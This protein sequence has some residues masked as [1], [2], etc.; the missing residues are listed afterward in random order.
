V[1]EARPPDV[2]EAPAA[3]ALALPNLI[4]IGAQKCGTSSLHNYLAVHPQ[5]SMSRIKEINFFNDDAK[6]AYG[7]EWYARHFEPGE[8]RGESSPAYTFLPESMGTAERMHRLVPDARLIYLVRDPVERIRSNYIHMRALELESRPFGEA[9][10]DPDG[11]YVNHTRYAT[12]LQPFIELF[13]R[14]RLLIASQEKLFSE[15]A[16][17]MRRIFGFLGVDESF[18][19]PEFERIWGRSE[20]K[21]KV[22]SSLARAAAALQTRGLFPTLPRNIRWRI[23]KVI[24]ADPS[25]REST[26]VMATDDVSERIAELLGDEVERLRAIAGD[27]FAEWSF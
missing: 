8:V 25:A 9:A 12:Q 14:E 5:I 6:W 1:I 27:R 2:S 24:R 20:G 7:P 26:A 4:V 17:T 16:D 11:I 22:Y 21:G 3:G 13:G 18:E 19:S 10:T 15:R 23:Q